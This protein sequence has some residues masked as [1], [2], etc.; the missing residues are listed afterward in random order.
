MK[1]M[2]YEGSRQINFK[3]ISIYQGWP[4]SWQTG[5]V[6]GLDPRFFR[7]YQAFRDLNINKTY[8]I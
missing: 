5:D 4:W 1:K 6:P 2:V 8:F 3:N 7:L